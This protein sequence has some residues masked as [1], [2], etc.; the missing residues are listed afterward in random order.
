MKPQRVALALLASIILILCNCQNDIE[1]VSDLPLPDKA[2]LSFH[3]SPYQKISFENSLS[4][5]SVAID[6]LCKTL[7]LAVYKDDFLDTLVTQST[8]DSGFGNISFSLPRGV[9]RFV[10]LAHSSAKQ[11]DMN[12]AEHIDFGSKNMSDVLLWS[13]KVSVGND[14]A[15]NI[16]MKRVVAKVE[17]CSTDSLHSGETEFYVKYTGGSYVLDA[18]TGCAPYHFDD[19]KIV[20]LSK[21]DSGKPLSVSFYTFPTSADTLRE[22]IFH[23]S[24][25]KGVIIDEKTINNVPIKANFITHLS[26]KLHN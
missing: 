7:L 16:T 6:S 8:T 18:T 20:K 5:K 2:T 13:D 15:L 23:T 17:I 9:Y 21:E 19:F 25:K 1:S 4:A 10:A 3:V 22:L 11:P 24:N 12:V 26:G 14:T